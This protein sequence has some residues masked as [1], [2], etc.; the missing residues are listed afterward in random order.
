MAGTLC[1]DDGQVP[2]HFHSGPVKHQVKS[3]RVLRVVEVVDGILVPGDDGR[4]GR[5]ILRDVPDAGANARSVRLPAVR[6]ERIN[7]RIRNTGCMDS[8]RQICP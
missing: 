8:E 4:R 7:V 2:G 1:E 6:E 5:R 3:G